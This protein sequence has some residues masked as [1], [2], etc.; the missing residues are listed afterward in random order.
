MPRGRPLTAADPTD[1]PTHPRT[2]KAQNRGIRITGTHTLL[3]W[4]L[5]YETRSGLSA[6]ESTINSKTQSS[7]DRTSL[8]NSVRLPHVTDHAGR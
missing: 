1:Q 2:A 6:A 8:L 5:I 4:R 3:K 7:S